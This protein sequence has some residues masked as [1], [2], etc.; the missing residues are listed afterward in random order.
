MGLGIY[1]KVNDLFNPDKRVILE[2]PAVPKLLLE[3]NPMEK[4]RPKIKFP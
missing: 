4:K 3:Y 2:D 1:G